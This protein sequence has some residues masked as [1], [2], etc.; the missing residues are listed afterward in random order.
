LT[1]T[2]ATIGSY[3]AI[4]GTISS[5][6][7]VPQLPNLASEAETHNVTS[8][9]TGAFLLA[10]VSFLENISLATVGG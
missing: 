8:F 6:V 4:V 9:I 10:I 1:G 5:T 3:V 2:N 7:P